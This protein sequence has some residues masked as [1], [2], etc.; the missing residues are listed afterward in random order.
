MRTLVG[1]PAQN[2]CG[3]FLGQ[4]VPATGW[5][6]S[7]LSCADMRLIYAVK[8]VVGY[9]NGPGHGRAVLRP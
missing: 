7:S 9:G 5:A 1:V 3:A 2:F 6:V 8:V 4:R